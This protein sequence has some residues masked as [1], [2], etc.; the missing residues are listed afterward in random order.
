MYMRWYTPW[1]AIPGG[2]STVYSCNFAVTIPGTLFLGL[3]WHVTVK[4]PGTLILG[5]IWT[6]RI[7]TTPGM[8]LL[9]SISEIA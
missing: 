3:L 2:Y 8:Q 4:I 1:N 5:L 6:V 9:G 7:R